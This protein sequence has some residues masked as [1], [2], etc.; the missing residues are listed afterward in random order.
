MVDGRS[1]HSGGHGY[2]RKWRG[3]ADHYTDDADIAVWRRRGG[4]N[5]LWPL[6]GD[7]GGAAGSDRGAE[8]GKMR[9]YSIMPRT[10][11]RP[12]PRLTARVNP[13]IHDAAHRTCSGVA[14][15]YIVGLTLA[16]NL[17][18]AGAGLPVY[19]LSAFYC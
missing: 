18:V 1:D 10:Q 11:L 12:R 16:V 8:K 15:A 6:S 7:T 9:G 13:T 3:A 2:E 4:G 17:L 14:R 19:N 5:D